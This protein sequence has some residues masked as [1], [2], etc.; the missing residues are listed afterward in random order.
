MSTYF[1]LALTIRS[2]DKEINLAFVSK[3]LELLSD[4]FYDERIIGLLFR[5][6]GN[7]LFEL[8]QRE[9]SL[10]I[11]AFVDVLPHYLLPRPR[12]L[13]VRPHAH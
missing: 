12:L 6:V 5:H 7:K 8:I 10:L 9:I 3:N 4:L 11:G 13:H 2:G 1:L